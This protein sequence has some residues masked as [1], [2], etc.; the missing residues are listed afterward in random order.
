[1]HENEDVIMDEGTSIM[2]EVT[3]IE[4][5]SPTLCLIEDKDGDR[6]EVDAERPTPIINY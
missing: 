6:W 2:S 3:F 1:M 4:Y 5:I